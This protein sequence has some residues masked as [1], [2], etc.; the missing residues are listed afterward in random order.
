MSDR[1][2]IRPVWLALASVFMAANLFSAEPDARRPA[3]RVISDKA[4]QSITFE[5]TGLVSADLERLANRDDAPDAFAD[6]LAVFVIDDADSSDLPPIAGKYAVN[7]SS[8][9]FTPRYPLRPG[10]RYRARLHPEGGSRNGDSGKAIDTAGADP[11]TLDVTLPTAAPDKPT[12]ITHVYPTAATLPEN[13]LKFYIHFSAPMGRGEAYKHLQLVDSKGN[14]S[15]LPFLE[16]TEELWDASGRRLTLFIDPGR[17]KRGVRPREEFGPVLEAG[18]EYTLVID[19][20][21]RDAGGRTLKNDFEKRF[22]VTVPVEKAID[23][24][25]WKI[26]PPRAGTTE[27]LVVRFPRPLDHALLERTIW[28]AGADGKPVAGRG[29][30]ADEE[31]RWEFR[32]ESRWQPGKYQLVVDTTLEDLAGNRI[33]R[34]FEVERLGTLDE[35]APDETVQIPFDIVP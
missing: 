2:R 30:A 10:L 16:L 15:D 28:P 11:I 27:A 6:I 1:Q 5:A 25:V 32:P 19:R 22:Q 21:W 23:R 12:E 17:I 26:I 18:K 20:A 35:R 7:G 4:R 14:K 31:R 29:T 34:P 33:G 9:R 8:L 24:A 13:Q 3:I